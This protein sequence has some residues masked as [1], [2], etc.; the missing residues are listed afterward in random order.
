MTTTILS[1]RGTTTAPS[2]HVD[3]EALWLNPAD[4]ETATGW[5]IK[6]EGLCRGPECIPVPPH[7]RD[8]FI[9]G[10]AVNIAAFWRRMDAPIAVSEARDVWALGERAEV[11]AQALESLEAPDFALRDLDGGIRRLSDH[12]GKKVLLT[13]WASW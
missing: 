9:R 7:E 1:D 12:R 10:G 6:P 2:A 5:T 13:T 11:R 4:V 3:G 8:A